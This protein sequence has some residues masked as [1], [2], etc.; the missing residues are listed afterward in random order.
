MGI[1]SRLDNP[2]PRK[3]FATAADACGNNNHVP[4]T[5]CLLCMETRRKIDH[6]CRQ[7]T[8]LRRGKAG[9]LSCPD[10]LLRSYRRARLLI[11]VASCTGV[12]QSSSYDEAGGESR[13]P[14]LSWNLRLPD[15][16]CWSRWCFGAVV[17]P[18]GGALLGA[19]GWCSASAAR[20]STMY[21]YQTAVFLFSPLERKDCCWL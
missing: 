4:G 1:R 7:T 14:S 19:C 20:A 11:V 18:N 10:Q 5:W 9:Q 12:K 2:H 15:A 13:A 17:P 21:L 3:S 6:V 16:V 8:Q